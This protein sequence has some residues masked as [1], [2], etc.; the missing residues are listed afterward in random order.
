MTLP[1]HCKSVQGKIVADSLDNLC[2]CE[3]VN[4]V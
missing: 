4:V 3:P 1:T 2:H